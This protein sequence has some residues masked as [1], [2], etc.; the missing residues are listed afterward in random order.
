MRILTDLPPD[1]DSFFLR[2]ASR[3]LFCFV[4]DVS[5]IVNHRNRVLNRDK[6]VSTAAPKRQQILVAIGANK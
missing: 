1:P 5:D 4:Y 6:L 3:L 2:A